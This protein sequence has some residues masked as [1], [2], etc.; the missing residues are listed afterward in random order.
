M[1]VG[2]HVKGEGHAQ[3]EEK[4]ALHTSKGVGRLLKD[5][6]KLEIRAYEKGDMAAVDIMIDLTSAIE[7]ADLTQK[8]RD[9][10]HYVYELDLEQGPASEKLGIHF[11]TLSRNLKA[12]L[13]KIARVYQLWKYN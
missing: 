10:I 7:Q 1:G 3:Y 2:S 4:Y 5:I 11:S 8:Q 9:A 13:G 12:A 6:H